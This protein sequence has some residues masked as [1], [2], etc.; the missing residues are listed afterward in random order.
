MR[1]GKT[2]SRGFTLIEVI[3]VL[4][5]M[6]LLL[7]SSILLIYNRQNAATFDTSIR[8]LNASMTSQINNLINGRN[9]LSTPFMC[10][11]ASTSN[12]VTIVPGGS[13]IGTNSGCVYVGVA[14]NFQ[15]PSSAQRNQFVS[16]SLVG[17]QCAVNSKP[18]FCPSP[19]ILAPPNILNDIKPV[20]LATGTLLSNNNIPDNSQWHIMGG[21]LVFNNITSSCGANSSYTIAFISNPS[22]NQ[23]VDLYAICGSPLGSSMPDYAAVNDID[24]NLKN[25]DSVE[26]KVQ[27]CFSSGTTNQS[28]L[29]TIY[30]GSG[31]LQ[32]NLTI[33]SGDLV[34]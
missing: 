2:G 8:A 9:N 20:A 32:S 21:G 25:V 11:D 27:I 31:Q 14:L 7:A 22:N 4:T 34:C 33:K 3:I 12:P 13:S 1:G 6:S 18:P 5:I 17:R 29:I 24:N 15:D 30:Y 28:G 16:Y 23:K 19:T 26:S 10:S